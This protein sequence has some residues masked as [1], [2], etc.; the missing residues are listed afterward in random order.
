MCTIKAAVGS[1][2]AGDSSPLPINLREMMLSSSSLFD[3]SSLGFTF[4]EWLRRFLFFAVDEEL[5][6][7]KAIFCLHI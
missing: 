5:Q 2:L 6:T 3:L 7:T 1:A 4:I